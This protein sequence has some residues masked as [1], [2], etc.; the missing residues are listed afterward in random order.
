MPAPGPS[1]AREGSA[2][3]TRPVHAQSGETGPPNAAPSA[4]SFCGY[5]IPDGAVTG[6]PLPTAAYCST[7]CRDAHEA[8]ERPFVGEHDDKYV[9]TDV[10]ALDRVLPQ[11]IRADSLVLFRGETGTGRLAL[12]FEL[13]WRAIQREEP[14][15]VV[16]YLDPP[17]AV[18]ERFLELGWN[19]LPALDRGLLSV[20]DCFTRRLSDVEEFQA[21][22]NRWNVHLTRALEDA[23]TRVHS[24][25]DLREVENRIISTVRE[26][27]PTDG[28]LVI[29]DSLEE[30]G[31]L[32]AD[33]Q[34]ENFLK[35]VRADVA[36]NRYVPLVVG[37]CADRA[38]GPRQQQ[39]RV[40]GGGLTTDV[41]Y[42]TDGIV[43]LRL[44]T[45]LVPDTRLK[46]LSV[47]KMR[48]VRYVPQWVTFELGTDG[49]A[50]FDP[51]TET[52]TVYDPDRL[53]AE[54]P[55]GG[56]GRRYQG[57]EVPATHRQVPAGGGR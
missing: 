29:L 23:V 48:G 27:D 42:F 21:T 31:T 26:L 39:L 22:K 54:A 18:V 3:N 36:H 55:V 49:H 47:R 56:Q 13:A 50:T 53:A 57:P 20:V 10:Q 6:D 34:V 24:P 33:P 7:A 2:H 30:V 16:S 44:N 5:P 14:A 37:Q 40:T 8:G 12:Q 38:M 17:T 35:E 45:E 52:R 4:C 9:R 11:G 19:V 51:S 15:V 41:T 25:D 43:D 28:S 46:Q 1:V 32:V